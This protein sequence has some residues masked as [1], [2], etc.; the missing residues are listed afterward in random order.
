MSHELKNQHELLASAD[1][2]DCR[3]GFKE[4]ENVNNVYCDLEREEVT[5]G[6]ISADEDGLVE[7]FSG[8]IVKQLVFSDGEVS[9]VECFETLF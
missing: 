8:V 5:F 4:D 1:D 9:G 2:Y 3:Q 7:E 6:H